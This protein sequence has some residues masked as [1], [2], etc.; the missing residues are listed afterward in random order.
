MNYDDFIRIIDKDI[1]KLDININD[2]EISL[3]E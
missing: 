2:E 3:I 1:K